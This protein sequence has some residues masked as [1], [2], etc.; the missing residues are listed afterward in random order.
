VKFIIDKKIKMSNIVKILY[1]ILFIALIL[2]FVLTF[3]YHKNGTAVYLIGSN[4]IFVYGMAA[5][6]IISWIIMVLKNR[7]KIPTIKVVPIIIF[8]LICVPVILL[9][10]SNPEILVVT[11]LTAFLV[12]FMYHTIENPDKTMLNELYRNKELVEQTY[13]DKSNFLFEMTGE[14]RNPL[15]N[16]GN[17]CN[18]IKNINDVDEIKKG[19]KEIYTYV[20]QLDFVVNDVL[21]V[22]NLDVQKIK[23]ID[24][25]YNINNLYGEIVNKINSCIDT[26]NIEFRASIS[27]NIPYLYGDSIKI[28]QIIMSILLNSIKKTRKGF[29]EFNIDMIERYDICRLIITIKDSGVGIS[30]DKIN[31]ILSNTGELDTE[32]IKEIEKAELNIK[33]CQKI[34]KLTGGS[35]M[36]K[37]Q[38]NKGTEVML[39]FNQ[40]KVLSDKNSY[41]EKYE[42][43][44]NTNKKVLLVSQDKELSKNIKRKFTDKEISIS[45]LLNGLDAIDKIKSGK[46]Y[47][48]I[49]V[50]DDMKE[51]TGFTTLKELKKI[52]KFNIPVIIMLKDNKINIKEEYIKDG[53]KDYILL[54]NISVE[55]DRIIDKY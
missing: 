36:I 13:E 9:Q 37:S 17:I 43:F 27:N 38:E 46:K 30:L 31:E 4:T 42:N 3:T 53:F 15:F 18:N 34:T 23:F 32:D 33:L 26:N 44:V 20:K 52:D 10:L 16:I 47:D 5:L 21:N 12:N 35:L 40:R 25:R 2:N 24:N 45:H 7:K 49:L 14:V 11:S 55:L 51:M 8:C 54:N 50:E 19:I 41:L 29:I 1:G 22:S 48:F 6:G 39:T 28:K